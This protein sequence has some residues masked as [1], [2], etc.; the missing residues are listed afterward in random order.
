[1]K[2]TDFVIRRTG[3]T[4]VELLAV[5]AIV[6]IL[7][8]LLAPSLKKAIDSAR[9]VK[10]MNNL[11]QIYLEQIAYT[12]D[13]GNWHAFGM[14]LTY[15]YW[16]RQ[17]I[18]TGYMPNWKGIAK[19]NN[20]VWDYGPRRCMSHLLQCPALPGD[21]TYMDKQPPG[22]AKWTCY[23]YNVYGI[24]YTNG[25]QRKLYQVKYPCDTLFIA[26]TSSQAEFLSDFNVVGNR[27]FN[28][29]NSLYVDGHVAPLFVPT[30]PGTYSPWWYSTEF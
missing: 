22:M 15:P 19:A 29:S 30:K 28:K 26:D 3:L 13:N 1:M 20:D 23:G 8:A 16:D 10:C 9:S 5:V 6:T 7:A 27:H 21:V 2:K 4:L 14:S 17:L 24:A 11:K 25:K 18:Y 12:N